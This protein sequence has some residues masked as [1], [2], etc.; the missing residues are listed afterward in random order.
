MPQYS[1]PNPQGIFYKSIRILPNPLEI[2]F[3]PT[4]SLGNLSKIN[5]I[6]YQIFPKSIKLLTKSLSNPSKPNQIHQKSIEALPNQQEIL[7]KSMRF[8]TKSFRHQVQP[9]QSLG[10]SST[11]QWICFPDPLHFVENTRSNLTKPFNNQSKNAK[12]AKNANS[13]KLGLDFG[14]ASLD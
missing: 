13:S 5:K 10:N 12:N 3:I 11:N 14:G 8:F 9:C 7:Q 6:L 4:K 2:N 1:L